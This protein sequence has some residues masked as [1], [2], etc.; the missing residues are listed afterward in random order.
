MQALA[1][2]HPALRENPDIEWMRARAYERWSFSDPLEKAVENEAQGSR[3]DK[4]RAVIAYFADRKER[5]HAAV[6][7]TRER[8]DIVARQLE[9][10]AGRGHNGEFNRIS[11]YA[12]VVAFVSHVL[13]PM[14]GKTVVEIGP[15]VDGRIALDYLHSLGART[16]GM[17]ALRVPT[18]GNGTEY[19][20]D[21]WENIGSR[22]PAS[23]VDAI[24]IQYM[25][26]DPHHGGEFDPFRGPL[27]VLSAFDPNY[28]DT[29]SSC[30]DDFSRYVGQEMAKVLKPGGF[31]A[32]RH[33]ASWEDASD[34][35]L[36]E[37]DVLIANYQLYEF[38]ELH[39]YGGSL[40]VYQK[41]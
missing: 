38:H 7:L 6:G 37:D 29:N 39:E 12:P 10:L 20:L 31:V 5:A 32:M 28:R 4:A 19:F 17:D 14:E 30:R 18:E 26:N 8:L 33:P 15:G 35:W 24:Y 3:D 16:V 13:N 25:H 34:F 23:T 22:F 2:A 9:Q 41:K 40:M 1:E 36:R 27:K 21:R 11:T